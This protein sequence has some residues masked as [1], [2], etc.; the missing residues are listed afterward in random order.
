MRSS[1]IELLNS[2]EEQWAP[3]N[4]FTQM[5]MSTCPRFV[6]NWM[7]SL[8][9]IKVQCQESFQSLD[10]KNHNNILQWS[11]YLLEITLIMTVSLTCNCSK[12]GDI[13]I[14]SLFIITM[15]FNIYLLQSSNDTFP[16]AMHI[17]VVLE[18]QE[19]LLPGLKV[20]LKSLETKKQEFK[21][22]VKIGRTHLQVMT[23][24]KWFYV[25]I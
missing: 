3:S 2:Q 8:H 19:R 11:F 15:Q 14:F 4:L 7:K 24:K 20:L 9:E 13:S 1:A 6:K 18:V 17:A 10:I 12:Q 22:I 5:T 23:K 16:T 25:I 21:D